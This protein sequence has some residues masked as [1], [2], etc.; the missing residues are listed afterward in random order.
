MASSLSNLV[1]NIS[2]G[3]HRITCKFGHDRKC[4]TC[5]IKYKYCKCFLEYINFKIDLKGYKYLCCNKNYEHK[6]DEK[7]KGQFFNTYKFSNHNN[8]KFIFLLQK[9]VYPYEYMDDLEKFI[10]I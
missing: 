7:L 2:E 9:G 1:N 6:Y 3:V 4:E 5:G 8:N 10:E